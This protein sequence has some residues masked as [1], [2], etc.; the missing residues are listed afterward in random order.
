[1]QLQVSCFYVSCRLRSL[2]VGARLATR[3]GNCGPAHAAVWT[4][5]ASSQ[6]D[7]AFTSTVDAPQTLAV[8]HRAHAH[9]LWSFAGAGTYTLAL[10]ATA[11]RA[12]DGMA[13]A[14]ETE[15]Y[16]FVVKA[17]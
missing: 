10:A 9:R 6:P 5:D 2:A 3:S 4:Y 16:T 13:L 7:V 8:G 17:E 12:S 1:M 11:V 15:L 14:S